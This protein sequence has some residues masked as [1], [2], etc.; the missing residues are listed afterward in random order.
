MIRPAK[1]TSRAALS[2][3]RGHRHNFR[4]MIV[5][6]EFMMTLLATLVTSM[7]LKRPLVRPGYPNGSEI[8][9]FARAGSDAA[10]AIVRH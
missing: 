3:G 5:I 9:L 6:A 10:G 4:H 2:G 1:R 8:F 7:A